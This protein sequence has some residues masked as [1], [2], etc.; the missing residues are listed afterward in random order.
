MLVLPRADGEAIHTRF[1]ALGDFLRAGDLLA[2]NDS[3][4]LRALLRARDEKGDAVK[5]RLAHRRAE[6]LWDVLLL[7]GRRI[8]YDTTLRAVDG[9]LNCAARGYLWHEFGDMNLIL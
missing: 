2:V 9:L 1:D 4:T 3:R 7:N 5:V 6:D 8:H